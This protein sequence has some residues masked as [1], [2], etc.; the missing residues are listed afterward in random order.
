MIHRPLAAPFLSEIFS[1]EVDASLSLTAVDRLYG[2]CDPKSGM[3]DH[4]QDVMLQTFLPENLLSF[5]DAASMDSSAELRMPFLDR[6]LVDLVLGL[7]ESSRASARPGGLHTKVLLR[8]WSRGRLST[9]V[10]RRRKRGFAS[11]SIAGLLEHDGP[12]VRA[13]ILDVP[14][15]REQMPGLE[16][17]LSHEPQYFRAERE[18]TLWAILALAIWYSAQLSL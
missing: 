9:E 4:M 14:A 2:S 10:V 8:E 5:A 17:W 13:R 18:G 11:G 1:H 15:L 6:D 7:P 12:S 3:L 16:T